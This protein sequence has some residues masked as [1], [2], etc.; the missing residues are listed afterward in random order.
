MKLTVNKFFLSKRGARKTVALSYI[1]SISVLFFGLMM[2]REHKEYGYL[3]IRG[4]HIYGN[5][6]LVTA[7]A[8]IAV[9]IL[10]FLFA[11][12]VTVIYLF[13]LNRSDFRKIP[14]SDVLI[15]SKCQTPITV[16]EASGFVCPKCGGTL[17]DVKGFYTRHP[18]FKEIDNE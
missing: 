12:Y 3:S 8:T 4:T 13:F 1:F 11:V 18:E 10:I 5:D 17:E 6:A 9:S 16:N 2:Y 15:C 7:V 14:P